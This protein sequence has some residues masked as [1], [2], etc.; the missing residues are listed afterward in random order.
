MATNEVP[1]TP[2][3]LSQTAAQFVLGIQRVG[4]SV[5]V[6]LITAAALTDDMNT[7]DRAEDDFG[8]KRKDLKSAY[9]VFTPASDAMLAWLNAAR[10]IL[11]SHFGYGWTAAWAAAGFVNRSTAI[12]KGHDDRLGVARSIIAFLTANPDFEVK[13]SR[14]TA[15][16]GNTVRTAMMD[17]RTTVLEKEEAARNAK[18]V[19]DAARTTLENDVRD[20]IGNLRR[21]LAKDDPR[22]LAFGLNM[23]VTKTTPGQPTNVTAQAQENGDVL[24]QCT[25]VPLAVRYRWRMRLAGETAYTLAA[26]SV[27]PSAMIRSVQAGATVEIIVQGVNGSQGVASEPVTITVPVSSRTAAAGEVS[28]PLVLEPVIVATNGN[29]NGNGHGANGHGRR[30]NGLATV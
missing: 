21:K 1:S 8:N 23:P 18:K 24:V 6:T 26:R 22:W 14:V 17:A 10:P 20:V 16:I 9:D 28:K 19:R 29:G 27:E 12:P 11:I 25:P 13:S 5:P 15:E 2:K 4:P 3:Q 7:F 30:R